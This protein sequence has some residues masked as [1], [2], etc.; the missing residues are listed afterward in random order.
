VD[1]VLGQ[2]GVT[3]Q[4]GA[5]LVEIW[6]KIDQLE[7]EASARIH[8]L[9]ARRPA[10]CRP[11]LVSALSGEG[12]DRL[13]AEIEARLAARRETLDL[14]LAVSDGAGLSWL[15][16]HAEV[17]AKRLSEDGSLVVTVRADPANAMKV[18]AKFAPAAAPLSQ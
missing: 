12:L 9:A 16:R 15:H 5:R 18:R 3:R 17:M 1:E 6:N 2:L 7:R 14:V 8:N 10:E 13:V 4:D 11:I